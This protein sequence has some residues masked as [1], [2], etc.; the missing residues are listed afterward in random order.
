MRA[1]VLGCDRTRLLHHPAVAARPEELGE[2]AVI[3][4]VRSIE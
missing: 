4:A 3:T 1:G 2:F